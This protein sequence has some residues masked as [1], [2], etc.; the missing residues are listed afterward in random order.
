M[1]GVNDK[2]ENSD[3][4]PAMGALPTGHRRFRAEETTS[5]KLKKIKKQ[6]KATRYDSTQNSKKAGGN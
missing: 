1:G 6:E 5:K 3:K 2:Q 4:R